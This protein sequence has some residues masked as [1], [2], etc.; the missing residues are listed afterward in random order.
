MKHACLWIVV[1]WIFVLGILGQALVFGQQ[2]GTES[3]QTLSLNA[4]RIADGAYSNDCLGF[5]LPIPAGWEQDP[6]AASKDG[7]ATHILGGGLTLFYLRQQA[8]PSGLELIHLN[9]FDAAGKS[10]STQEFV[11][12]LVHQQARSLHLKDGTVIQK[13]L[14]RDAS[15]VEYGGKP[16]FRAEFK[17]SDPSGKFYVGTIYTKFR[18]YFIGGTFIARSPE[19]LDKTFDALRAISF[20]EDQR[21]TRCVEDP[22]RVGKIPVSEEVAQ[23][24][25]IS[26]VEPVC[27]ADAH[28]EGPVVL[29]VLIGVNGEVE[30]MTPVSGDPL[31]TP[32]AIEAV[33][34]WKFRPFQAG[35]DAAKM[36]TQLTVQFQRSGNQ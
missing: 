5:S 28:C 2:P 17:Q 25:L 3:P 10:D 36:E 30:E 14:V 7:K 19:E 4:G 12:Q 21:D 9:A 11:S 13:D 20:R 33:K 26:K 16:F 35:S 31:L 22:I 34:Q 27:P 29:K 23:R 15:P 24:M 8:N 1:S 18:G 6:K 32:A